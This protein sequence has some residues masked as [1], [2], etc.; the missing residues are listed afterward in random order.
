MKTYRVDDRKKE[1]G[2]ILIPQ[3][4]YQSGLSTD[5]KNVD[6]KNIDQRINHNV[7]QY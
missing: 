1:I 6:S 2:E 4:K 7:I 3:N 5:K